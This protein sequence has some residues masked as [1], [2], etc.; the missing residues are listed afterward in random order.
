MPDALLIPI[1]PAATPAAPAELAITPAATPAAP[2][3]LGITPAATPAAPGPGLYD[4]S[5]VP[6]WVYTVAYQVGQVV[7]D[8]LDFEPFIALLANTNENPRDVLPNWAV[9]ERFAADTYGWS[10]VAAQGEVVLVG[11]VL[12]QALEATSYPPAADSPAWRRYPNVVVD[13]VTIA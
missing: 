1:T 7:M 5:T 6:M 2:A 10:Y 4:V 13:A 3:G 9:V 11:Y 8:D 12:W